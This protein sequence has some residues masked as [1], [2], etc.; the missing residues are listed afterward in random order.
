MR[1]GKDRADARESRKHRRP[2]KLDLKHH[3]EEVAIELLPLQARRREY[4]VKTT[5]SHHRR[6]VCRSPLITRSPLVRW[7]APGSRS[8]GRRLHSRKTRR[9]PITFQNYFRMYKKLSGMMPPRRKPPN[10]TRSTS[11]TSSSSRP[12]GDA[13]HRRTRIVYT[14]QEKYFAVADEDYTTRTP[15]TRTRRNCKHRRV[16]LGYPQSLE[17]PPRRPQREIPREGS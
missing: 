10:S 16:A 14:A 5:R 17:R 2:R 3:I 13:A 8:Q 12:T 11:S 1:D 15:S 6:R 4:V 9:S 7:S